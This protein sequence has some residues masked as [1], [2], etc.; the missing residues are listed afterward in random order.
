MHFTCC[1]SYTLCINNYC[2]KTQ[3]A[4]KLRQQYLHTYLNPSTLID[5]GIPKEYNNILTV[6]DNFSCTKKETFP[7]VF[8][9]QRWRLENLCWYYWL[10]AAIIYDITNFIKSVYSMVIINYVLFWSSIYYHIM[11]NINKFF[12][13]IKWWNVKNY[14]YMLINS[15][16]TFRP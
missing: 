4:C 6:Y 12:G 2:S 13:F 1:N 9:W 15:L 11:C 5:F 8:N 7:P 3:H 10:I 14:M 16:V